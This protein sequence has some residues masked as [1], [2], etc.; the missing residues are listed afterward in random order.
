MARQARNSGITGI[1]SRH[2]WFRLL[3]TDR[4]GT[5]AKEFMGLRAKKGRYFALLMKKKA[6]QRKNVTFSLIL[7]RKQAFQRKNA[8]F[9]LSEQKTSEKSSFLHLFTLPTKDGYQPCGQQICFLFSFAQSDKLQLR[10][11]RLRS[12]AECA[13]VAFE[14]IDGIEHKTVRD[15]VR[16]TVQA[17]GMTK[18]TA[19]ATGAEGGD[20][21]RVR[22]QRQTEACGLH[23]TL[24]ECPAPV[25]CPDAL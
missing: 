16:E 15:L 17:A 5:P 13:F 3:T 2:R 10:H 8:I 12:A 9:S 19:R 23:V 11:T 14:R 25:E 24:F 22:G 4:D 21:E 1:L 18:E 20:R 6:F 7:M